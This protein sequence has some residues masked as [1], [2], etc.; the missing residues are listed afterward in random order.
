MQHWN[1]LH[2]YHVTF[3]LQPG[4]LTIAVPTNHRDSVIWAPVPDFRPHAIFSPSTNTIRLFIFIRLR[5]LPSPLMSALFAPSRPWC[6]HR[7]RRR[8]WILIQISEN[9]ETEQQRGNKT[10]CEPFVLLF[11]FHLKPGELLPSLL[12]VS[13]VDPTVLVRG[14][15]ARKWAN[16]PNLKPNGKFRVSVEDGRQRCVI[17]SSLAGRGEVWHW[18][19]LSNLV[20]GG[21][22]RAECSVSSGSFTI[23]HCGT[24][25][26]IHLLKWCSYGINT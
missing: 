17:R 3:G 25:P 5:D 22:Q 16:G 7:G 9:Q 8:H 12:R 13:K 18:R 19:R 4:V 21:V 26:K 20:G 14:R 23:L 15:I 2:Y 1:H 6:N 11:F 24:G 10:G